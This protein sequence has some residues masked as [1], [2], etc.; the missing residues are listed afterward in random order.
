MLLGE[1]TS[2]SAKTDKA[3]W[4]FVLPSTYVTG[5][6]I[7]FNVDCNYTGSGTVTAAS[8]T[9][10]GAIYTESNTGVEAAATVTQTATQISSTA[11]QYPFAVFCRQ[12]RRCWPGAGYARGVRGHHAGHQLLGCQHRPDQQRDLQRVIA[13]ADRRTIR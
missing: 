3:A 11:T 9:V 12:R 5:A 10:L 6:A 7:T 2:S 1:A 8:C 4:E 13:V